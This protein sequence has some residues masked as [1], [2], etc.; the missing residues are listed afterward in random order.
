MTSS[1]ASM[2]LLFVV[3]TSRADDWPQWLGP[4][5]DGEYA[6]K[7]GNPVDGILPLLADADAPSLLM[8]AD[9]VK[10]KYRHPATYYKAALGLVLL[11]EEI[12]GPERFDPAFRKYI[13]TWAYKHPSPSDFFRLMESEAGEDLGWF[14]RGWYANNW[15]LDLAVSKVAGQVV[16]IENRDQLVMPATLRVTFDDKSQKV[17][18]GDKVYE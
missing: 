14:W 16:T 12:I 7:G 18:A 5:R 17:M 11:R 1:R 10:E 4:K 2:L 3:P 8:G 15:Q 6:P 13:A 9:M